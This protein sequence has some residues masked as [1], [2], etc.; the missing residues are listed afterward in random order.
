MAGVGP[1]AVPLS[2]QYDDVVVHANDLNPKSFHYLKVNAALNKCGSQLIPYNMD[3]R[4]FVRRLEDD[5]VAYDFV[6]MNLPAIAIEFLDVFRGWRPP[7]SSRDG[8]KKEEGGDDDDDVVMPLI[9]V[10]CFCEKSDVEGKEAVERCER[11]LGCGL[12]ASEDE[13][14]VRIVRD[15]SPTKNMLCV[16]FRLPKKVLGLERIELTRTCDRRNGGNATNDGDKNCDGEEENE[17]NR[18]PKSKKPR[19]EL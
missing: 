1:F 8:R 14:V 19:T 6:I 7:S 4:A 17:G 13:L 16:S 3:G 10:H 11:A 9:N 12:S 5:N 2:S 18:S 15:V